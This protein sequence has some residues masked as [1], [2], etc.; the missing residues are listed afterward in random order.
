MKDST[1]KKEFK[2]K[3]VQRLRNIVKGRYG[4]KTTIQVG[5][6]KPDEER[7]EGEVWKE[8]TK[9]WT[10]KNGIKQTYSKLQQARDLQKVPLFCPKCKTLMKNPNDKDFYRIHSHCFNC[11]I[12]FETELKRDGKWEE[13]HKEIH[14]SEIEKWKTNYEN[15]INDLINDNM[16]GFVTEDGAV[17]QWTKGKQDE[18]L[19]QKKEVLAYLETLYKR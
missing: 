6:E 4:D 13:Y 10:I 11:Q 8:G 14:N 9:E 15:W 19:K 18:L 17:E 5:Y 16:R 12:K 7:Q 3:D 2:Q 1:L